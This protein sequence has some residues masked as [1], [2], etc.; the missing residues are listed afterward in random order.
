MGA[1]RCSPVPTCNLPVPHAGCWPRSFPHTTPCTL[2]NPFQ[3]RQLSWWR[4]GS[5]MCSHQLQQRDGRHT[6]VQQEHNFTAATATAAVVQAA[7]PLIQAAAG[8]LAGTWAQCR[9]T[10]LVLWLEA[11]VLLMVLQQD[12]LWAPSAAAGLAGVELLAMSTWASASY[13]CGMRV[14]E[15]VCHCVQL[16][17]GFGGAG[18][19]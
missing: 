8:C 16:P 4:E 17:W 6:A 19:S 3:P 2:H 12:L 9:V 18:H 11:A 1:S 14:L 13:P 10:R 15:Q 7:P 5:W